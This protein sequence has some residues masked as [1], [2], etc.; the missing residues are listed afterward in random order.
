MKSALKHA[1]RAAA[2][3]LPAA[4]LVRLGMPA[5]VT[6]V[7]VAVLMIGVICWIIS[8]DDRTD[9]VNRI[10]LARRGNAKCLE[11]SASDLGRGPAGML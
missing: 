1:G 4:V 11:T 8:S 9:R 7:F 2:G 10:M 3:M 6:L 5:L